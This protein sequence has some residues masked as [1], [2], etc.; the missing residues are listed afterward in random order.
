MLATRHGSTCKDAK[1]TEDAGADAWRALFAP[2]RESRSLRVVRKRGHPLLVLSGAAGGCPAALS[3]YPTQRLRARCARALLGFALCCGLPF[4][5]ERVRLSFDP[6][7]AFWQF[8]RRQA[9]EVSDFTILCGN[10]H[11]SGQRFTMLTGARGKQVILKAGVSPEARRLIL[12]ETRFLQTLNGACHAP[13]V[14]G[15]LETDRLAAFATEFTPGNSPSLHCVKEAAEVL[16][17]WVQAE[18]IPLGDIPAWQRLR[19]ARPSLPCALTGLE[20]R[21]VAVSAGHGDFAPWNIKAASRGWVVLDWERGE[22]PGVP[23]WD[24]FHFFIQPR[25]LVQHLSPEKII[26][27]LE[28]AIASAA[29]QSY[30]VKA[31]ITGIEKLLA[32]GYLE[33]MAYVTPTSEGGTCLREIQ[34][35]AAERWL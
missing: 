21:R 11:T 17:A 35:I 15:Q 24:W 4:P 26:Q 30:A 27:D 9:G 29:F 25:V 12:Q 22:S 13:V 7:D 2:G 34:R 16:A 8:V 6:A 33:N 10:P 1:A 3:L 14:L 28:T 31:K 5:L 20:N 23:G 18:E 32:L 19:A